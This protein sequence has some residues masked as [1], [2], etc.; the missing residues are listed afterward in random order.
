MEGRLRCEVAYES[1][2]QYSL[3]CYVWRC[4]FCGYEATSCATRRTIATGRTVLPSLFQWVADWSFGMARH[5]AVTSIGFTLLQLKKG[6][7]QNIAAELILAP[8][9][10]P[11]TSR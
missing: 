7:T 4:A 2:R 1:P 5:L 11:W 9:A 8:Q 3:P 6:D 10:R